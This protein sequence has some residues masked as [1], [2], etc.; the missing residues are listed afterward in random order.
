MKNSYKKN[1]PQRKKY[2][3]NYCSHNK[4]YCKNNIVRNVKKYV[5]V[6]WFI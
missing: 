6:R 5:Y 3:S 2:V 4:K 1:R